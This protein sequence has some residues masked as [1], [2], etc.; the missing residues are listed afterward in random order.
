MAQL[1]K[2]YSSS[3]RGVALVQAVDNIRSGLSALRRYNGMR[4][5]LIAT[6]VEEF[7]NAFGVT[8]QEGAQALSDRWA[9]I[10]AGNYAGLD[11][12]LDTIM[13]VNSSDA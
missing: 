1:T 10:M 2:I 6:S 13:V 11:E 7:A 12:F 4:E 3:Q 5:Q 9:A 8:T